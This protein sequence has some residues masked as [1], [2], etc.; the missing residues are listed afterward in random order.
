[1]EIPSNQSTRYYNKYLLESE[2]DSDSTFKCEKC[3]ELLSEPYIQCAECSQVSCLKCFSIGSE[4]NNHKNT[5]SYSIR[6]DNFAVFEQSSWTGR[7]EKKFLNA[8]LSHGYGNWD[9]ISRVMDRR[10]PEECKSHYINFYL[11]NIFG[12][13]LG[14]TNEN[15]FVPGVIPFLFKQNSLEPPRFDEDTIHFTNSAGYRFA[16]SEFETPYDNGAEAIVSYL[17]PDDSGDPETREV[18]D[19]LNASIF[20]VY[21]NRLK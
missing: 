12:K 19:E 4:T 21:N 1:M 6:H 17:R 13:F 14:L 3:Q 2:V 9:G 20:Q 5:H 16:R 11:N 15:L 7:E 8:L 10:S 18:I